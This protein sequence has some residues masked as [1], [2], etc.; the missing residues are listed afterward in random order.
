MGDGIVIVPSDNVVYAPMDCEI[1][2]VFPS[3]HA[4]GLVTD[5]G[6]EALIHVGIDTINMNGEGFQC[7]VKVG[8][9]VKAGEKLLTFNKK[10]IE[11][12]GLNPVVVFVKTEE[13]N[14][15][16]VTFRTGMKVSAG[17]DIV[18]E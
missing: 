17:K 4:I 16:P 5:S 8:D 1:A 7:F 18:G 12:K 15:S 2:F 13:G 14:Q 6:L 9:Q 3:K 10:K 11:E